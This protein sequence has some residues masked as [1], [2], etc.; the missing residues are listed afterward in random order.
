[1]TFYAYRLV[2]PRATFAQDMTDH[3]AAVMGEHAQ[4][5]QDLVD[6]GTA[7]AFGPVADPAGVWGLALIEVDSDDE[8]T[9]VRD[10]DPAVVRDVAH[11]EMHA[12][13]GATLRA[14]QRA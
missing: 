14:A 5:W 11:G 12:M 7:V 4:Y 6:R 3:E 10:H 9:A 13:L 8:A 2:A 1:M